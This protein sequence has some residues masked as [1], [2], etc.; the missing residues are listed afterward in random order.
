MSTEKNTYPQGDIAI[1]GMALTVPGADNPQAYWQNLRD[2]VESIT[3]LSEKELLEAGERPELISDPNYVPVAARLQNF[4]RFDAE[5]FGFS[6]KEAAILDPQHRKF[7]EVAWEALENAGHRTDD[8]DGPVGVYAGCGMGSYFYFNICSNPG[9]VDDVGMFL[10]RHTGNDKDFL[11]TRVSHVFDLRGPSLNIQTACSTSL[12]AIHTAAEAL[13]AGDCAMAL[14]GGVTVELPQGRGYLFKE[15]EILSPDG[16]C[17]AFDHRAEGTVF[18]SGAGVVVLR[19]LE[20]AIADGDHVWAVLKG[21]AINNDGAAKAGYLAP[22]V[23]GQSQAIGMALDSAGV[24]ADTIDYV[25][26]HGTGTYLGDPIEIAALTDAYR[27]DTDESGYC[28]IGSVKTNIGHL[29]T[30]AGIASLIKATLALHHRQMPPSLGYEK[31]N[32]TIDFE[33]SPFRVNDRL[34]DWT[35]RNGPRRAG[36]NSLGVGGTNAHAILEEAPERAASEESD[37]PFHILCLS[38]R[39]RAALDANTQ[40]LAAHLRANPNLDLAD[41]AHTLK[42]GRK[43]FEKRRIVVA[44]TAAHAANLLEENDPRHVFTHDLLGPRPETVFMFPG[45]GAQYTGMARDLYETEPVFAEWMDRGLAH[46]EPQLDYDIRALWLPEPDQAE[47]AEATLKQPS[48]QLPLIMI[49]EMALAHLWIS[50]G[51]KPAALVGHSMGENTAACLAGVTSFEDCIDLVLL[52]GR[53]FDTVPA[54]G[55]ISVSLS[56]DALRP[57]LGDDLDIASVNAP[58]LT[59]ASGPQAAL[60]ALADRLTADGIEHQRVQIDIAAHSRML[61]PILKD[62]GDFLRRITL[63]APQIPVISNCTGQPLT[64]EQATDPDYW[65]AQLRNTVHFADCVEALATEGKR[66]FLEV[67]PG[68]ALSSLAQMNEHVAPGQVLSSL[69]HPDQDMADDEYFLGVI[70]RLWA[71]GVE[72]DWTQI[73]GEARRNRV[74]LPTYQF[75]RSRYF[76]EPGKPAVA[77]EAAPLTR[78]DDLSAWGYRPNWRPALADCAVD[79]ETELDTVEPCNWLIF[80]DDL[81]VAAAAADRLEATGHTV[82]RVTSGD[83]FA[84]LGDGRFVLAP[85]QGRLGYDSLIDALRET[86]AMPDRIGH[87]WLVT[88]AEY[89]RPGS[90]FFDRNMEHGFASLTALG[91]ALAE[92]GADTPV[93]LTAFTTGATQVRGE[94]L[95][96]PEKATLSGPLGVIPREVPGFTCA[97]VDIELPEEPKT[98]FLSHLREHQETTVPITNRLLEELLAEPGNTTAAWRGEKRFEL[99]Y[100]PVALAEV[101]APVFRQGGTYL[102]TGGFG[103]I[104]LTVTAD[105]AQRY[106]AKIILL[107]RDG[108]PDEDDWDSYLS[109][110]AA[111]DRTSCRIRAVQALRD[112]GAKIMCATAD[113]ANIDQMRA[114]TNAAEARFGQI[115]GVIHAAGTIDDAPLLAKD[116]AAIDAVLAPKIT[117]LRVLDEL[118]PDGTLDQMVLFSSSSTVT[119]PAGQVDYIAANDYLNAYAKSRAGGQTR[120]CA[121]DWGVWAQVGMAADAMAA[122]AGADAPDDWREAGAPLLDRAGFDLHGRRVFTTTLTPQMWVLDEHR[123]AKGEALLPGTA[124]LDLAAQ[125]LAAHGVDD[126][127]ELR[128]LVFL[129]PLAVETPREMIVHLAETAEGYDFSV[130][131]A[132]SSGGY[133]LHAQ[134]QVLP[135]GPCPVGL[136][137][138]AIAARCPTRSAGSG[139]TSPQE[140]HLTFGSRWRVLNAT[141]TGNREGLAE[142]ALPQSHRDDLNAGYR[143]HPGLM[144]LA[145]GWAIGLVPSYTGGSLWVPVSYHA[146]RVHRTLPADI[147]SWVRLRDRTEDA[148]GFATFDITLTDPQG[149]I[150]VEIDDFE[151]KR[152]DHAFDLV[153]PAEGDTDAVALGLA[154][155]GAQPLSRDEERLRHMITQGIR[156][157]EGAEALSR[158]L[159]LNLPQVVISSLDL[160]A[161]RAQV[162]TPVQVVEDEGQS[163][164]RPDLDSDYI[165]PRNPTEEALAAIWQNLLGVSQIGMNDSFFDLGGHSLIAVRLFAQINREMGVQFPISVLFEA[166]TIAKCAEMIVARTGGAAASGGEMVPVDD[167]GQ[168]KSHIVTLS[169]SPGGGTPLFIV[170]GMF[171]NVLNLRHLALLMGGDRPVYGL[172]ARGLVGDAAPH[173]TFE[174]AAA[175]YIAEMRQVQPQ[176]PYLLGGFSGGGLTAYEIAQQLTAEGEEVAVLALLDT[177]LPVRASLSRRDKALIKLNEIRRKGPRYLIEWAR[178]RWAWEMQKRRGET[179]QDAANAFNN[180]K[181]EAAF[182]RAASAYRL[183]PWDGPMTLYRPPLDRHWAVSGG[184][185]VSAATE[186][187]IADNGW[188]GWAPRVE[189]IEVPGDHDSMVLVPNVRTLAQELKATIDR[190]ERGA[191]L[192]DT[193]PNATAAE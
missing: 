3:R 9:L 60:D 185:F 58:E 84:D 163:F 39:S 53:L 72:A 126:R 44:E 47:A 122:R 97:S 146:L 139:M 114:V 132:L 8:V 141:A 4:D 103:G 85:E 63:N 155:G 187:V 162:N 147:R 64:A 89:F 164:D 75:Q 153:D 116:E 42:Q 62:F 19:R 5:F 138:D 174:E 166:P 143:L 88:G 38:G 32:P 27:Q 17:H 69:R 167:A 65:V 46:L 102:I 107:S 128:D 15:N 79:I 74:P 54:G 149:N 109:Q 113:V 28:R 165:A 193:R 160:E 13:R 177:P 67:G 23:D 125:A 41:V 40:A 145:T 92:A 45:G 148:D 188:T 110:H 51:V 71:C 115:T 95:A 21:S 66:V 20:D 133:L 29:D 169:Q 59:A 179:P 36:V 34:T 159:A 105:L 181:I 99:G 25:E 55:M 2:G 100:R 175:D 182:L 22:S 156:P 12:V 83:T 43:G 186:Y 119:R 170:A 161:L 171:G 111:G 48:V 184:Q 157:D 106:D 152:L 30:A 136:D 37:W 11:S 168:P 18:G 129:R 130:H 144:D 101:E 24:P 87:F 124:Y 16:H 178:N 98:G 49:T 117:G 131:S 1:V 154:P 50:W 73:W 134:A 121:I 112:S 173:E 183:K 120:V 142:L 135:V 123:T 158:A 76:I 61:D 127:F 94:A 57:Y 52:R 77:E 78:T 104:G 56:E 189:V 91:Q 68:K 10:L 93:H 192:P 176:G 90:S 191:T 82:T 35:P 150:C 33:T 180:A 7:L 108:L 137:L 190:A 140:A 31:P 81:G 151:M 14:A 70:G 86:D 6:P 118:F 80:E 172:Q 26:C 96:Y